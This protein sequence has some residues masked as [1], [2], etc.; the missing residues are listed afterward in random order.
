VTQP[1][2]DNLCDSNEKCNYSFVFCVCLFVCL[3]DWLFVC[4]W[5][6]GWLVDWLIGWL[7]FVLLS[8]VSSFVFVYLFPFNPVKEIVYFIFN[9]YSKDEHFNGEWRKRSIN[10][11]VIRS[12]S[13][14]AHD[15][16]MLF[17]RDFYL[18]TYI[19]I[20][21]NNNRIQYKI[22]VYICYNHKELIRQANLTSSVYGI[23]LDLNIKYKIRAILLWNIHVLFSF[24][25]GLSYKY[26]RLQI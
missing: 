23:N 8:L 14:R 22:H 4:L 7:V 2:M 3:F 5:L 17:K 6:V 26:Y 12:S 9:F 25:K 19:S 11:A 1:Y 24:Q 21:K 20:F 10:I 15:P 18:N 16:L 13:F